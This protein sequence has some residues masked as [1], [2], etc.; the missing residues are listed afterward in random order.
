M[1]IDNQVG[2]PFMF[3]DTALISP[4]ISVPNESLPLALMPQATPCCGDFAHCTQEC[5]PRREH[6][7]K[8]NAALE[9][10]RF[11]FR[12]IADQFPELGF[13][14]FNEDTLSD[15]TLRI[16]EQ[17]RFERVQRLLLLDKL[18]GALDELAFRKAQDQAQ[19]PLET[20]EMKLP[21]GETVGFS[22]SGKA[23]PE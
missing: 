22:I 16:V 2:M 13:K 20:G 1:G 11:W 5:A 9:V 14:P 12:H 15:A 3:G 19:L 4:T 8:P 18:N 10:W 21:C 6:E 23:Q 7:A 17:I